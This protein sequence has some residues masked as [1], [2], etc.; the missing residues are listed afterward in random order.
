MKKHVIATLFAVDT[1]KSDLFIVH[2]DVEPLLRLLALYALA[3]A[4]PCLHVPHAVYCDTVSRGQAGTDIHDLVTASYVAVAGPYQAEWYESRR[5]QQRMPTQVIPTGLP[6]FDRLTTPLMERRRACQLLRLDQARPV[7][8]Y[9]SSWRQ[10]TNLLG[11]HDGVEEA[12]AAFLAAAKTL[13]DVQFVI[14]THPRGNNL[15]QHMQEA[16]KAGV[17]AVVTDNHLD[18]ILC[19]ADLVLTYESSNVILDAACIPGIRLA[20]VSGFAQDEAVETLPPQGAAIAEA[21][22]A[23]LSAP[24]RDVSLFRHKYLGVVDGKA[25]DRVAALA[26]ELCKR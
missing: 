13:P 14:K 23:L 15:Q 5:L 18:I 1:L 3:H 6:Q 20:A 12:Y 17:R 26:A 24:P 9:F 2:N 22:Q 7:V 10:D 19:A 11:C 21:I 16:D 8:M 25:K 4:I